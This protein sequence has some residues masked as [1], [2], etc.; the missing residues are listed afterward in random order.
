MPCQQPSPRTTYLLTRHFPSA[1]LI[2]YALVFPFSTPRL[3]FLCVSLFMT[4]ALLESW[5][6]RRVASFPATSTLLM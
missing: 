6:S 1:D 3:L 5:Q 2:R 4:P